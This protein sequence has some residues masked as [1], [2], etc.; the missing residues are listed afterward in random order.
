MSIVPKY[1]PEDLWVAI[2][3]G[4]VLGAIRARSARQ[5]YGGKP[6]PVV[7]VRTVAMAAQA[8]GHGLLRPMLNAVLDHH[9]RLGAG[10]AILSPSSAS[11]YQRA[12]FD[13]AGVWPTHASPIESVPPF[14]GSATMQPFG[15]ADFPEV[16]ECHRAFGLVNNGIIDRSEG[17]WRETGLHPSGDIA[18]FRYMLRLD[19]TVRAYCIY[20]QRPSIIRDYYYTLRFAD[21]VWT[22]AE[23]AQALLSFIAGHRAMTEGL[24]WSGPLDDPLFSLLSR[25]EL[26]VV[27]NHVWMARGVDI[28]SALIARGYPPGAGAEIAFAVSDP[29]APAE[30]TAVLL[31]VHEGVPQ[32]ELTDRAELTMSAGTFGAMFTGWLHPEVAHRLGRLS[33]ATADDIKGLSAIFAGPIPWS[34]ELV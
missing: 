4:Q 14:A 22:D 21:L 30:S 18:N 23:S 25:N 27:A 15:E 3:D 2:A 8:R 34:L 12:G 17:W 10:L 33:G 32:V 16:A 7:M 9:R 28:A 29:L 1:P 6:V 19:G 31:R 24:E 13:I 11:A 26:K 20:T 5:F